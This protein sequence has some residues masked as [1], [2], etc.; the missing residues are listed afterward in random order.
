M[1]RIIVAVVLFMMYGIGYGQTVDSRRC[2]MKA[3]AFMEGRMSKSV[4][5]RQLKEVSLSIQDAPQLKAFNLEDGGFV[6]LQDRS[7]EPVVIGYSDHG[8]VSTTTM[9]DPMRQW[10][11]N[12]DASDAS[13]A[14]K[15]PLTLSYTPVAPL[16]NTKWGQ[17]EPFNSMCPT[18]DDKHTVVGCTAVTLA[19]ILYHYKSSNTSTVVEEYVNQATSTEI[20]VDYSKGNYDWANMLPSYDGAYT[21]KQAN[22]VARLMYEAGVACHCKFGISSTSGSQ[23]FC[24]VSSSPSISAMASTP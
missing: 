6:L 7:G 5:K 20:S 4:D 11:E 18:Y 1:K 17:R 23:P 13:V 2:I 19:Q 21:D 14:A 10:L 24:T 8:S 12:Y 15:A 22:A 3:K 16:L 9:P